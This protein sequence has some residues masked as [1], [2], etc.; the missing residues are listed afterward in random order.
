MILLLKH[1]YLAVNTSCILES[2]IFCLK[3][4]MAIREVTQEKI[5]SE[6]PEIMSTSEN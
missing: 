2:V 6:S 4:S 1:I 3:K 5:M